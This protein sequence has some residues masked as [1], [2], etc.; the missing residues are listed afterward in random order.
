VK[1]CQCYLVCW[2]ESIFIIT[3]KESEIGLNIATGN[4]S[5]RFK[6]LVMRLRPVTK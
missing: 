3:I 6:L 2:V 5:P 1:K 4:L